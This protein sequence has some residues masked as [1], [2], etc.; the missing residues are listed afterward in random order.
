MG[1]WE[2]WIS[3]CLSA[4]VHLPSRATKWAKSSLRCVRGAPE[5]QDGVPMVQGHGLAEQHA[6][7]VR[8]DCVGAGTVLMW[9]W[10]EPRECGHPQASEAQWGLQSWGTEVWQCC[11]FLPQ[12]EMEK[13]LRVLK[14]PLG[15]PHSLEPWHGHSFHDP[16]PG[17]PKLGVRSVS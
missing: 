5:V 3:Q 16:I 9:L 14:H 11:L 8:G 7:A 13:Y 6:A 17:T 15:A 4:K 1:L 2:G 10:W 12:L